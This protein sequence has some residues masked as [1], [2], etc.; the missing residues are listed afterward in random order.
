MREEVSNW[1]KQALKDLESAS[2]NFEIKEYYVTA[3]FS[4]QATEKA[5]K[6]L[7]IHKVKESPGPTHSLLFLGKNVKIP[8]EFFSGLRK[9]SPDFVITRYPDA[10]HGVPYELYDE[11]IAKERL[12]IAKNVIKWVQKELEI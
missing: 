7:Y 4:Q 6:A 8:G 9:L 11:E 10:A 12:E 1:W 2:K 3:F 5:L